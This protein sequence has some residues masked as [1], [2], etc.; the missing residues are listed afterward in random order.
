MSILI[1]SVLNSASDRLS[2]FLSLCSFSG[3]LICSFHL[4]HSSLSQHTCYIV[5]GGALGIH[6]SRAT[7]SLLCGTLCG[8]EVRE[9]TMPLAQLSLHFQSLPL[10]PTSKLCSSTCCPGVHSQMGGLVYILEPCGYL[11]GTLLRG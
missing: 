3:V 11:Q 7:L 4:G 9:G 1:T 5:R 6:Q 8:E 10:L 2:I